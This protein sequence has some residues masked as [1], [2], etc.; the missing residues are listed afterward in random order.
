MR[1]IIFLFFILSVSFMAT[2]QI[3]DPVEWMFS[4]KKIN[5]EDYE[6]HMTARIDKGWH[7]YSQSTP[8]GG[9]VPTSF[10]FNK[11]PLVSLDDKTKEVGTLEKNHEPLFGVEVKQFSNRVDFVQ[12]IKV[13]GG[14][15]TAFTGSV[16]FMVCNNVECLP[17][18]TENFTISIK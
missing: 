7:I 17:P 1:K 13:K 5:N 8:E 18:K 12:K 15:K 6:I 3:K 16:E 2:A 9:P 4:A 14:V 11:N 10:I